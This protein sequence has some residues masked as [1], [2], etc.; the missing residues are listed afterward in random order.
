V[1]I[2]CI[3]PSTRK[4]TY[5]NIQSRIRHFWNQPNGILASQPIKVCA[6]SENARRRT[7]EMS[8]LK[9]C[10]FCGGQGKEYFNGN[11]LEPEYVIHCDECNTETGSTYGAKEEAIAAIEAAVRA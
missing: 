10:P 2:V 5:A 6:H 8:D 4:A 3:V 1:W 11:S 9:P 7:M